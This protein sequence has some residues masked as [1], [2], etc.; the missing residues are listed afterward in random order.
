MRTAVTRAQG[1]QDDES[2]VFEATRERI[3]PSHIVLR[4]HKEIY[5]ECACKLAQ[6]FIVQGIESAL[7]VLAKPAVQLL[8]C[9]SE[10]AVALS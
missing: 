2:I 4:H 5:P 9:K 8:F 3:I 10:T 6:A 7:K 1:F